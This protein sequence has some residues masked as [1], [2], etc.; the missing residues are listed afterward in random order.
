MSGRAGD[1]GEGKWGRED[2]QGAARLLPPPSS[3][4]PLFYV[5]VEIS[6]FWFYRTVT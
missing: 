4:S 3:R 2:G 6:I 5:A 1:I